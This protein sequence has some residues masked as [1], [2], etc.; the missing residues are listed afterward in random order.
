[1]GFP[2]LELPFGDE[3]LLDR[4][5]RIVRQ[6]TGPT[7]VVAAP[8]Q[9]VPALPPDVRLVRDSGLG[10]GPIEA[11]AVGLQA[12]DGQIDAAYAAG[13]DA[14]LIRPAFIR[15][16]LDRLEGHDAAVPR[17]GGFHHPLAAAYSIRTLRVFLALLAE[18]RL[19]PLDLIERV[20]SL[21]LD[22][23]QFADV[24]PELESLVNLNR[25]ADYLDALARAG[26]MAP[27][28]LA[29]RLMASGER[30]I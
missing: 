11:L 6:V 10:R 4:V 26:L 20:D 23:V 7:V 8:G 21:I 30:S 28:G 9:D 18:G 25:P 22:E 19:R 24:D 15:R 17:T 14:P 12:L 29:E 5:V 1:M 13:C 3:R 27:P 16:V 2:K